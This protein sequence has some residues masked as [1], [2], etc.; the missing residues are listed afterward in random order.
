MRITVNIDD[1]NTVVTGTSD[2]S[3]PPPEVLAAAA[4]LGAIDGGP[5]PNAVP[6]NAGVTAAAYPEAEPSTQDM[7]AMSAGPAPGTQV[8]AEPDTVTENPD[9]Q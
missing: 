9:E 6:P 3:Q 2:T 4:A 7:N 1:G 5:A 8:E